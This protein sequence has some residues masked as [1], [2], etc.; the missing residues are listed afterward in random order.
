[1]ENKQIVQALW[2]AIDRQNWQQLQAFFALQAVICWHNTNEQF[3]PPE[4]VRAN[5]E[6][7]GK[8]RITVQRLEETQTGVVSVVHVTDSIQ[9]FHATSFFSFE[10]GIITRLDEYWG[11][12]GDA[13]QWRKTKKI[14]KPIQ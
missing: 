5:S 11:D 6:Y 3:T 2:Q 13:P 8:W 4:F 12:D 7:P 10:N 9:S 14:G 1:M